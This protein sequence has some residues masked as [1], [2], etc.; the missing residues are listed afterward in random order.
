[1]VSVDFS[2]EKKKKK[3]NSK[4]TVRRQLCALGC[5][6]MC[7]CVC[8]A[9]EVSNRVAKLS[10]TGHEVNRILESC[11]WHRIHE[12]TWQRLLRCS[13]GMKLNRAVVTQGII[14]HRC[15]FFFFFSWKSVVCCLVTVNEIHSSFNQAALCSAVD[16][17]FKM[18]AHLE[19]N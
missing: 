1:M 2:V 18:N 19:E 8:L 12:W 5:V 13:V 16:N 17:C 15:G 10:Q 4:L 11:L 6:C 14:M 3:R 9:T 7:M